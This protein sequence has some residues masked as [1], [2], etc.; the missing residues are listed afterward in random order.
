MVRTSCYSGQKFGRL[1]IFHFEEK[2]NFWQT[3]LLFEQNKSK[4]LQRISWNSQSYLQSGQKSREL[5]D[6]N[7][8]LKV[9]LQFTFHHRKSL[10]RGIVNSRNDERLLLYLFEIGLEQ[11]AHA[12]DGILKA[13]GIERSAC[14]FGV[15]SRLYQKR[16]EIFQVWQIKLQ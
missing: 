7:H 8:Q 3:R 1:E 15:T 11:L 6:H 16:W 5:I 10:N 2:Q 9:L 12:A 13:W 4:Y 14:L